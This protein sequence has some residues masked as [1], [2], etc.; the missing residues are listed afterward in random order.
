MYELAAEELYDKVDKLMSEVPELTLKKAK[1]LVRN[2]DDYIE[3]RNNNILFWI[4]ILI[5]LTIIFGFRIETLILFA[6]IQIL[7]IFN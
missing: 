6:V 7:P 4:I 1:E 5:I 2:N 3:K